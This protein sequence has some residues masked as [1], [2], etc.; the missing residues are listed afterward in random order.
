MNAADGRSYAREVRRSAV[1][2][3]SRAT[4]RW[5][6]PAAD[7]RGK[8]QGDFNAPQT[9]AASDGKK[10]RTLVNFRLL[11]RLSSKGIDW[12]LEVS[13]DPQTG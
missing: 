6:S 9:A 4:I 5:L 3:V 12:P 2:A 8:G 1:D 13:G 11:P 10:P 7:R